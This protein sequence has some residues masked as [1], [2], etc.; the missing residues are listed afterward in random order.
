MSSLEPWFLEI[1]AC[2]RCRQKVALTEDGGGLLCERCALV[3][4]IEDGIPQMLPDSGRPVS[5]RRGGGAPE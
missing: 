4:P 1:L 5:Q 3:Y 2:T